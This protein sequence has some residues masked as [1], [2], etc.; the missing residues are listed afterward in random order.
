MVADS[1]EV[2]AYNFERTFSPDHRPGFVR[3]DLNPRGHT[4]DTRGC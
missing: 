2:E 4:N 3:F 1:L